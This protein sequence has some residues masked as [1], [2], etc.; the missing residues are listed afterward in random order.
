MFMTI[1]SRLGAAA[2]FA[3]AGAVLVP[4]VATGSTVT[5]VK[6]NVKTHTVTTGKFAIQFGN[7]TTNLPN[8]PER[9]DSLTWK[10]SSGVQSANLAAN[11]GTYCNDVREYWGQSYGSVE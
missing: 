7:A 4:V 5:A 3:A 2:I 6:I 11:G 9:I 10:N 1:R 8:D